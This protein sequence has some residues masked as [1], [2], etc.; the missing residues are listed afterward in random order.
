MGGG[1]G[2]ASFTPSGSS[3][4][5]TESIW[6][7]FMCGV[8]LETLDLGPFAAWITHV[9]GSTLSS[10]WGHARCIGDAKWVT[11]SDA[12]LR[13]SV[14][15]LALVLAAQAMKPTRM[16][17]SGT[18]A[19][20][21]SPGSPT[22]TKKRMKRLRQQPLSPQPSAVQKNPV[23]WAVCRGVQSRLLGMSAVSEDEAAPECTADARAIQY[24]LQGADICTPAH[25]AAASCKVTLR[26][27]WA[28]DARNMRLSEFAQDLV[29]QALVT[30]AEHLDAFPEEL[31]DADIPAGCLHWRFAGCAALGGGGACRATPP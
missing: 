12:N 2:K 1:A 11:L 26:L 25:L 24:D 8:S 28:H 14:F 21:A 16:T 17:D 29:K 15:L 7:R 18:A 19:A 4:D 30:A 5:A 9:A 10:N 22:R 23:F 3:E 20:A 13:K 6:K 27:R 31:V